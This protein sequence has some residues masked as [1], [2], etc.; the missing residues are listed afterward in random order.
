MLTDEI[1]KPFIESLPHFFKKPQIPQSCFIAPGAQIIGDVVLGEQSSVWFNAVIRGDVNFIRIGSRTNIQDL[2]VIH[3]ASI[4]HPTVIG[5]DC[6]IGHSAVLHAARIGNLVLVGMGS[7]I[8]DGAEIEDEVIIG[9]GSLVTRGTRIPSG[10]KVLG[11]PAR[12]VGTISPE[13]RNHLRWSAGRY[14]ELTRCYLA[15]L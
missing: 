6:T 9:A 5:D 13:E 15:Q 1:E 7:I 3:V 10:S 11:R 8:L 2:T 12:V 14:Q 4:N